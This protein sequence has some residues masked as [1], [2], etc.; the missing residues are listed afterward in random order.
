MGLIQV[1]PTKSTIC[2]SCAKF[3][4]TGVLCLDEYGPKVI[5]Q[6]ATCG[7]YVTIYPS[8]A[9]DLDNEKAPLA[10]QKPLDKVP[11]L[12]EDA[13]ALFLCSRRSVREFHKKPVPREKIRQLLN[14]ARFA[15]TTG[16]P[17][18]VSYHVIDDQ[19]TLRSIT[20]VTIDG[21]EEELQTSPYIGSQY[22]APFAVHASNYRQNGQDVVLRDAPCLVIPIVDILNL[23]LNMCVTGGLMIG[24]QKYTYRRLVDRN[25]PQVSW[26]YD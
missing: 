12:D 5:E 16:N 15:L 13:A 21:L 7:H 19:D 17:Q 25:P 18:G 1:N 20:S 24:Y 3:F 22:E 14:I 6:I 23:S 4:P 26:Q 10:N 8:E 2:G 9:L 11:A